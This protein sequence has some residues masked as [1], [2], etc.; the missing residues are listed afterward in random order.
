MGKTPVE[1]QLYYAN[2]CGHCKTFYPKGADNQPIRT[3][4]DNTWQGVRAKIADE[5]ANYDVK[6]YECESG[7]VENNAAQ[8]RIKE[9]GMGKIF[10]WPTIRVKIDD[11]YYKYGGPRHLQGFVSFIQEKSNSNQNG[12]SVYY[13]QKYHKYK[14]MYAEALKQIEQLKGGNNI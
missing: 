3:F 6:T 8:K 4:D 1:I 5:L 14:E 10:G 12:G 11:T 2:W 13:R 7:N 9:S